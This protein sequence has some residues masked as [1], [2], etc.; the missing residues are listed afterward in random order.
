MDQTER[1]ICIVCGEPK[2]DGITIVTEFI[3]TSCESEMVH[4]KVEDD[5][6]PFFVHQMKQLWLRFHT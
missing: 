2:E 3:C 4:T 1:K 5:R 6:Y